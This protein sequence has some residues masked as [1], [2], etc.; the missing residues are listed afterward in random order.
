L[1]VAKTL[2]APSEKWRWRGYVLSGVRL[3][4]PFSFKEFTPFEFFSS[5]CVIIVDFSERG[6]F[7]LFVHGSLLVCGVACFFFHFNRSVDCCWSSSF[8]SFTTGHR[9][10]AFILT[11][12]TMNNPHLESIVAYENA[13]VEQKLDC[14]RRC[15][16]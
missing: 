3:A 11:M 2:K 9:L 10:P 5:M 13:S 15:Q 16:L 1:E 14:V 6:L 12:T 4:R 7:C 8:S